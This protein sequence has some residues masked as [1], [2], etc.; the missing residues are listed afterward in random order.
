MSLLDERLEVVVAWAT[1]APSR[2]AEDDKSEDD[3]RDVAFAAP[4][5]FRRVQLR[6]VAEDEDEGIPRCDAAACSLAIFDATR[7]RP[8]EE[9]LLIVFPSV[10]LASWATAEEEIG[11]EDEQEEEE[12]D[13]RGIESETGRAPASTPRGA[14]S[15]VD[16]EWPT[17]AIF[18]SH[19]ARR[20]NMARFGIK[21]DGSTTWL[22][23]GDLI[24]LPAS[25]RDAK[26]DTI[27]A[28]SYVSPSAANTG[29]RITSRVIG[30]R[31]PSVTSSGN[32]TAG[33][34][35]LLSTS[36]RLLGLFLFPQLD[37]DPPTDDEDE[38]F[39]ATLFTVES[40]SP[41]CSAQPAGC[42]SFS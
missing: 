12:E 34:T 20:R 6:F 2:E 15:S 37:D 5:F 31:M 32:G 29:S 42:S 39:D 8:L 41:I 18:F 26:C 28:R 40:C 1:L 7:L 38:L 21:M 10:G 22:V 25:F 9:F 30:H 17:I 19:S 23:I 35:R 11:D 4:L 3:D 13:E 36:E 24:G 27:A 14:L 33:G 16:R